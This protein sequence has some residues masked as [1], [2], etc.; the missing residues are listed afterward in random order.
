MPTITVRLAAAVLMICMSRLLRLLR[1]SVM[2][3]VLVCLYSPQ[4]FIL[5]LT[6]RLELWTLLACSPEHGQLNEPTHTVSFCVFLFRGMKA[7]FGHLSL[8]LADRV[9]KQARKPHVYPRSGYTKHES[10]S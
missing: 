8:S 3:P 2:S 6:N 7:L 9:D 5:A 1:V 10:I 4:Q